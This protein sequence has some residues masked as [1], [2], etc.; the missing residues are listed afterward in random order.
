MERRA[1]L[2][3]EGNNMFQKVIGLVGLVFLLQFSIVAESM[4][5]IVSSPEQTVAGSV[6]TFFASEWS[7]TG[8]IRTD[9]EFGDGTHASFPS[10]TAEHVYM[11]P[12]PYVVFVSFAHEFYSYSTTMNILVYLPDISVLSPTVNITS[13]TL[14]LDH[15]QDSGDQFSMAGEII[16]PKGWELSEQVIVI[17]LG[18]VNIVFLTNTDLDYKTDFI[19][20]KMSVNKK[21]PQRHKFIIK[22]KHWNYGQLKKYGLADATT[23]AS[24]LP[25]PVKVDIGIMS[26]ERTENFSYTSTQGKK[27]KAKRIKP[28]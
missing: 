15:T 18:D 13:S 27:G 16:I 11:V 19:S 22:V 3:L 8:L 5:G 17:T 10:L 26:F 7:A 20:F 12:G 2:N 25:I 28:Q 6:T 21:E 14:V 1:L 23:K 4:N 9:W 24:I